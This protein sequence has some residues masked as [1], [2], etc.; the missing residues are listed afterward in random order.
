MNKRLSHA[1]FN[2]ILTAFLL[3]IAFQAYANEKL[4]IPLGKTVAVPAYGVKKIV[5]VNEGVVDI[6]NVSDTEI[7][8]S[9]MGN[10]GATTQMILWDLTGRR[11]YDIETFDEN[12]LI[13]DKFDNII[14]N[15]NIKLVIFPDIAYLQGQ[16]AKKED[17]IRA[18]TLAKSLLGTRPLVSLLESE[19][20]ETSLKE[21]IEAALKLPTV[22]VDIIS[23][24]VDP[25]STASTSTASGT[26]DVRVLLHGTV[27]NQ[28]DYM[29]MMEIVKG[30]VPI[31]RLSNL[32][33]IENP[34]QVVFQ[35]F[36]LQVDKTND[37]DL[38]IN[39][40]AGGSGGLSKGVLD[41]LEMAGPSGG[42]VIPRNVNPFKMQN[43]N[44]QSLV[45][46]QVR[47]WELSG[48]AK[49]IS[50]PNLIVYSSATPTKPS[51][52]GW[53][54]E[55]SM[56]EGSTGQS[57]AYVSVGQQIQFRS[58]LDNAGNATW[59]TTSANL[60]LA[61]RD[62]FIIDDQLKFSVY[63]QQEQPSFVNK[64]G[65][66]NIMTRSLMTTVKMGDE[67][68]IALGG[69]ISKDYSVTNSGLPLLRNLP[70]VGSLFSHKAVVD[71]E[72]ELIIL[73]TPKIT[74]KEVDLAGKAKFK[75]VPVP[76]RSDKLE[77]LNEA[78]Q[79]IQSG[80]IPQN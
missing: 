77:R 15:K 12:K 72:N 55:S 10:T 63:I 47:A 66:P 60:Q 14:S 2:I 24:K 79:R 78:F 49:V 53:M 34:Y 38:G 31:D 46:A 20:T 7:I 43:I 71:K 28:N 52:S 61:I 54:G 65:P 35:A 45:A 33:T 80:H 5:A 41:F 57:L 51:E 42:A 70:L 17:S 9:A 27:E 8:I 25:F 56:G 19:T 75:E 37:S 4:M 50:K 16:V 44:R 6:L 23:P 30:F 59:G 64:D 76:R 39:W 18:E 74:G 13:L 36:I 40:G 11:V 32:V 73:L 68:T 58:N 62:L 67:E 48:K 26:A 3:L 1:A 29:H 22:Q 21:R 69:L